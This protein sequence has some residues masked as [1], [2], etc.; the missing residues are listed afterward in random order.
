MSHNPEGRSPLESESGPVH[1]PIEIP[2]IPVTATEITDVA[3]V[4]APVDD[5]GPE[6]DDAAEEALDAT[7]GSAQYRRLRLSPSLARYAG[8][9]RTTKGRVG[10]IGL[11]TLLLLALVTPVLFPQGYDHQTNDSLRGPSGAAWL[12]TDELGRDLFVR[13]LYGLGTDLSLVFLAVPLSMAVGTFIGLSAAFSERLGVFMQRVLDIIIGFPTLILGICI[14]LILGTGWLSL[15]LAIAIAGLPSAG[16]LARGAW[17]EQQ[18]REYVLAARTLGV[19]RWQLLVRH[20]LPN[21]ADPIL[22]QGAV[23]MVQ[24]VFIEAAL[25]IVGLGIQPPSPSLG[26]LLNTGI[27]YL[28]RTPTYV[29]GPMVLMILLA[30]SLSLVADALNQAVN[31]R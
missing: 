2:T 28:Q 9:F 1:D 21:A 16:R 29:V 19:S 14:V 24:A 23:Y 31:K 13:S 18:G 5:S 8:A 20:V 25:S 12:G 7:S 22:V 6:A 17:L 11:G 27:R 4:P 10:A 26:A 30:L 3:L 15:F